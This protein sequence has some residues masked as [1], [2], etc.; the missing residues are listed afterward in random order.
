MTAFAALPVSCRSLTETTLVRLVCLT[1]FLADFGPRRRIAQICGSRFG[2]R[3][4]VL[5][6]RLMSAGLGVRVRCHGA[7]QRRNEA[8]DSGQPRLLARHSGPRLAQA[9]EPPREERDRRSSRG[10]ANLSPWRASFTSI[11]AAVLAFR[12]LMRRSAKQCA[13]ERRLCCSLRP[14][15]ATAIALCASVRRISNRSAGGVGQGKRE[16]GYS[17][18]LSRLLASCGASDG[19][20]RTASS[21]MVR[22]RGVPSPF[23]QFVP[24]GGVRCDLYVGAPIRVSPSLERKSAARLAEAFGRNLAIKHGRRQ[25][26]L[27]SAQEKPYI[28][29]VAWR[30]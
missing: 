20:G 30:P 15:R 23:F 17:A 3:A 4:P 29:H 12:P 18:S 10:V 27:C 25:R 14:R 22:G 24:R 21:R 9:H 8:A 11:A 7:F 16:P 28:R 1:A 2:R 19:S 26:R 13:G 6:N 5:L